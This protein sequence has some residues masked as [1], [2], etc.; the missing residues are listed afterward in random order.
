MTKQT[1]S[2]ESLEK[3]SSL[4]DLAYIFFRRKWIILGV[5]LAT[6]IPVTIYSFQIRSVYEATSSLLVKPGKENIYVAPV[7][8]PEGSA[9]PTIVQRVR[10]VIQTEIEILKS[11]VV[12]K[13]T[14]EQIG[15]SELMSATAPD[16]SRTAH[17]DTV[18]PSLE[19]FVDRMLTRLS[20][21]QVE[22]ADAIQV[23]FKSPDP[24]LS[25]R[26]INTLIDIYLERHLE[27]HHSGKSYAFFR[28]QANQLEEKLKAASRR[29]AEFKKK[30]S[31]TSF[32]QR[33]S[34]VLER[35]METLAEKQKNDT[36]IKTTQETIERL[37]D[38]LNELPEHGY[39]FQEQFSDPPIISSL[40]QELAGLEVEK[41]ELSHKFKPNNHQIVNLERRIDKIKEMLAEEEEKFHGTITNRTSP[42]REKLTGQIIE[43][44]ADLEAL[45]KAAVELETQLIDYGQELERLGRLEPQLKSLERA[46]SVN[47][48]NYR[49]YL[50]KFEESRVSDAMDAA[51]IVSVSVLEPAVVPLKPLPIRR[52]LN[53]LVSLCVGLAAG[54]ALAF[55]FEYFDHT[56]KLPEDVADNLAIPT[57]G[58]IGELPDAEKPDLQA[59][60]V[61]PKPP[62][63]YQLLK[64]SI[65]RRAEDEKAKALSVCSPTREEGSSTVALHVAAALAKDSSQRVV[66]LDAN[67]RHPA[68][69]N[70]A[71]VSGGPGLSEVIDKDGDIRS[72][73]QQSAI[74]NLFV[75]P[76]GV[77]PA[78]PTAI[79]ESK[80]LA[81]VIE[82][83]KTDFDWVIADSAAVNLY[84]D[85]GL[86]APLL[87]G[88]VLVVQAENK[89]AEVAMQAKGRLEE[90]GATIL[91]GVLNRRRYVIPEVVYRRLT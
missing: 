24:E 13:R 14:I 19:T 38:S 82:T 42:I 69:H 84:A 73:I 44:K 47:E 74:P 2:P 37:Q 81:E 21:E 6:V 7:G 30:Y 50:T 75:I 20:V 41:A 28:T 52:E 34:L 35:Y 88:V 8:G 58:A 79:L 22:G 72:V 64:N 66:L 65:I 80:K 39:A 70:Y 51:K 15:V 36:R 1:K 61:S 10:E 67:L 71:N 26:F 33:K 86:L 90:A 62:P 25:A 11:R 23:G 9:P 76:S 40:K 16:G 59:L 54:L 60:A 56:L 45:T 89:R 12:M 53:I 87:D 78:N 27:V 68:L 32:N 17:A 57:L 46:V 43:K 4:R 29:L 49:L 85:T 83:L 48:S 77:G 31:I 63:H 3:R 5:L 55:L 91:G 18:G